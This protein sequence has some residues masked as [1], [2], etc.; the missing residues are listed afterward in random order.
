MSEGR[1]I[2]LPELFEAMQQMSRLDLV[3]WSLACS[4]A[5]HWKLS[6]ADALLDLKFVDETT[7]AKALAKANDLVY[8]NGVELDCDFSDVDF[9]SFQD[10]MS[11]GAIP[12]MNDRLAIC[13]PYDDLRGNLG[14]RLCQR[15]WVVTERSILFEVLRKHGLSDWMEGGVR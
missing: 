10:L 5:E 12:L 9:D 15:T 4:F 8:V 11:V 6:V 2:V 1:V 3:D 7:L 14:N 13:N